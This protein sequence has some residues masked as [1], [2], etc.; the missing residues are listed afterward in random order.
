MNPRL[1]ILVSTHGENGLKRCAANTWP[2]VDGASY[3]IS[4]QY[5]DSQPPIPAE[6]TDRDDVK[7]VF[8]TSRGLS[9]NRNNGLLAARADYVLI[10]DNDTDFYADA[11]CQIIETFDADPALDITTMRYEDANHRPK[12]AYP[13]DGHDISKHFYGYYVSS[14]EIALR[15]SSIVDAG[16][17]FSE[18]A[19]LGAPRLNQGEEQIFIMNALRR[20]LR[21][22]HIARVVACHRDDSTGRRDFSPA[23]LR[24]RGVL[25]IKERNLMGWAAITVRAW[26]LRHQVPFFKALRYMTSGGFYYLRH[27]RQL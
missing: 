26:K 27:R 24:S 20:G 17:R 25:A 5:A 14:I 8:T 3:L 4:C 12:K 11:L 22:R 7:V 1:E 21:G 13:P 16:L 2:R 6:L 9:A 15:R 19:G 10:A 18:L 23:A